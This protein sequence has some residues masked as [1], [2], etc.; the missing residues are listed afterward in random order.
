MTD[1]RP[2]QRQ[3]LMILPAT[4]VTGGLLTAGLAMAAH[5]SLGL[6]EGS[7]APTWLH[8]RDVLRDPEFHAGL[9]LSIWVAA[10]TTALSVTMG[11]A[12]AVVLQPT[13]SRS[14]MMRALLQLPLGVPHLAVAIATLALA[15]PTGLLA[16]IAFALGLITAPNDLP[17][18]LYDRYGLGI[19]LSYTVK[20]TPFLAVVATALLQRVDDGYGAVARTLGASP[21]QR[22]R[23][24]TWPLIRPG[25]GSAAM[26]VFAFVFSAFETPFLMGRPYPSMLAVLAQQRYATLELADR[27]A[28]VAMALVMTAIVAIIVWWQLRPA[29]TRLPGPQPTVF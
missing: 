18:L 5:E 23:F 22:F 3:W 19:I 15:A 10:V 2:R 25:V 20:E 28:A 27:P 12:I 13:L 9:A 17:P 14:R 29:R 7:G 11:L 24:V 16:R 26:M 8:Y 4:A 21:W 1:P 6:A